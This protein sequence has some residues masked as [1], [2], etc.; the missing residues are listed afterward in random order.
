MDLQEQINEYIDSQTE[1]K[2]SEKSKRYGRIN[3]IFSITVRH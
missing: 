2:L 1:P 3:E